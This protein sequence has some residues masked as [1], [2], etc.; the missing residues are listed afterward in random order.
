ME[1]SAYLY[2]SQCLFNCL[3]AANTYFKTLFSLSPEI[4]LYRTFASAEHIQFVIVLTTRILLLESDGW[5]L[6]IARMTLNFPLILDRLISQL[7]QASEIA[8]Q[9]VTKFVGDTR[10]DI[11]DEVTGGKFAKYV[12]KLEWI[13]SWYSSKVMG[14][15]AA[16]A[17]IPPWFGLEDENIFD[18]SWFN[19]VA[20]D[21][22]WAYGL[23]GH[24]VW[25]FDTLSR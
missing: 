21:T 13:K 18:M 19:P 1:E 22:T 3:N 25:N 6:D 20:S 11:G 15:T 14:E 17:E 10:A 8:K 23:S 12:R 5:D 24:S 7:K 9:R 4:H 16:L 2:R